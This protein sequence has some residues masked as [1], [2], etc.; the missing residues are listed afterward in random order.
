MPEKPK[1][2]Q[3][4]AATRRTQA[5]ETPS[6]TG[7]AV[8][9]GFAVSSLAI[10]MAFNLG[11]FSE[12]TALTLIGAIG[13]VSVLYFGLHGFFGRRPSPALLAFLG[14][15]AIVWL[16]AGGYPYY[17]ALNPGNLVLSAELARGATVTAGLQ[18]KAGTYDLVVTGHFLAAEGRVNRTATYRIH[19]DQGA[20]SRD[21]D[22]VFSQ[23]WRTERVGMG[24][25]STSVPVLHTSPEVRTDIESP[26]GHDLRLTLTA[27]SEGV[28]DTVQLHLYGE[29]VPRWALYAAALAALLGSIVVDTLRSEGHQDGLMSGLTTAVL[30][31]VTT[32]TN[33]VAHTPGFPQLIVASL[34]GGVVG[35]LAGSLLWRLARPLRRYMPS[36]A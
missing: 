8:A 7:W 35:A 26:D 5:E 32:F 25:R 19:V 17:R 30:A 1:K 3:P 27:L 29:P 11:A 15:F 4:A 2:K 21:L 23:E 13:L 16:F 10:F 12:A 24:R 22:G 31:A 9:I 6:S 33:S 28:R 36:T 14:V 34:V 20:E 18:G